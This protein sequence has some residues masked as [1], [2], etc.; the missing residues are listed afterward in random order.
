M[1]PLLMALLLLLSVASA[2]GQQM[3]PGELSADRVLNGEYPFPPSAPQVV[4]EDWRGFA[5]ERLSKVPA[6]GIHPRVLLSPEDLP[7]LRRRLKETQ[8]GRVLFAQLEERA[9]ASLRDPKSWT[10]ALYAKMATG[11]VAGA[12]ALLLEHKGFPPGIGHY[13]Q[14]SEAICF[15]AFAA[16]VTEDGSRGKKAATALATY[17]Q[18]VRPHLDATLAAPMGD[19][20]TRAKI[21]PSDQDVG[22]DVDAHI[23][24]YAYDFSFNFMTESQRDVVRKLIADYTAGRVWMGARLPHQFRNWNWIAI[25]LGQPLMALAIEG[26]KGYDPRVYKLGV[27]I[28]KDYFTYGISEKGFSTEAVGY[29]QFG[30]VW[31]EPFVVAAARRGDNLLVQN[32]HRA[33]IDWYLNTMEPFGQTWT[34]HGDGGDGGPSFETMQIWKYFYP[35]DAKID[36]VWQNAAFAGGKDQLAAKTHIIE[37]LIFA[38]DGMKSSDGKLID[39]GGGAKLK[40][41]LADFDP[42][43]SSLTA[44]TAWTPDALMTE[45]EC[46]TDSVGASHEHAD[47]AAFTLSAMGRS[48]AKDNF[49]SVETKYHNS[50]L[51]D[52]EGQGYWPGPGRWL[53]LKDDGN[54]LVAAADAKS[55]YDWQ[56]PKEIASENPDT[57]VRD[58][59]L[60]WSSFAEEQTKFH[61]ENK[62]LPVERDTRP[63]VVAHWKGFEQ[64][65]PRMWDEDSWPVRV[66]HNPVQRAFRSIALSRG[67]KPFLLV[68]DDIQKDDKEHLYEWLMQ[69]GPDTDIASLSSND[70]VLC[71]ATVRRDSQGAPKPAK[72]DR[73]L[74]VR[75][76]DLGNPAKARDYTSRPAIRLETFDRKDT[77]VPEMKPGSMSGSRT[78]AEDKRLVIPSLSVAPDFKVLLFPMRQGDAMPETSW[79]ADRTELTVKADGET[80]V[81]RMTKDSSG[82]TVLNP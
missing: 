61:A 38:M 53:G 70:I 17:A 63:A 19:D 31:G 4:T 82:R 81:I 44:R 11:D 73:E 57:F 49:R 18:L 41:P 64:G 72:G 48:W 28:A 69:T 59:Y 6:P 14:W 42:T 22:E 8:T 56:W 68:V 9:A 50:I 25:G 21:P 60:R 5:K 29:T 66:P 80:T 52:G 35:N 75:V 47:R 58:R 51:I 33:M 77:L 76:L 3:L 24:G 27:Q 16:M 2:G 65:D 36:F 62:D 74:L 78:Y 23:V 40:L 37:P 43:R 79:N 39:Y 13:Q 34:S 67:K 30:L 71:D 54:L 26:E 45:F 20:S 10:S 46:R 7:D 15:D 55:A 32:H 12:R 1:R